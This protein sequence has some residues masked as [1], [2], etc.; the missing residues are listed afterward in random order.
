MKK[1][2]KD[3]TAFDVEKHCKSITRGPAKR[4]GKKVVFE[5][6]QLKFPWY[7]KRNSH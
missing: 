5:H 3:P 1:R 7:D 4:K 6:R 2:T